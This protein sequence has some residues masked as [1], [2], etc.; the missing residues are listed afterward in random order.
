VCCLSLSYFFFDTSFLSE[1]EIE[2]V[3][4]AMLEGAQAITETEEAVDV[5]NDTAVK[6]AEKM[7]AKAAVSVVEAA[8]ATNQ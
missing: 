7:M 1:L 4:E 5:P 6:E 3:A 2:T 8:I